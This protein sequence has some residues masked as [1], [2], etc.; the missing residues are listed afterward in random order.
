MAAE[1]GPVWVIDCRVGLMTMPVNS[2]LD[3]ASRLVTSA[4]PSQGVPSWKTTFGR[5]VIVQVVYDEFG[6]TDCARYGAQS[7]FASTIVSGS[8]TVRAYMTPTS[9]KRPAVGSKPCSSASTPKTS[10]PPFFGVA[11]LT[12]LRPGPFVT[13]PAISSQPKPTADAPANPA[14]AAAPPASSVRRSNFEAIAPPFP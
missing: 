13:A 5:R 7:P 8:N 14:A 6:T 10:D 12:P 9:S 3:C 1:S 2:D 4:A 11:L